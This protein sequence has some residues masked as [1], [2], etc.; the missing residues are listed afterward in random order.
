M[1][2]SYE[3]DIQAFKRLR[4]PNLMTITLALAII[5]DSIY[6]KDAIIPVI[7]SHTVLL[8]PLFAINFSALMMLINSTNGLLASFDARD[9]SLIRY[10]TNNVK[11]AALS[12][13]VLIA[14]V[15][16]KIFYATSNDELNV[17]E[18]TTALSNQELTTIMATALIFILFALVINIIAGASHSHEKNTN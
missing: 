2:D 1:Y 8:A 16:Y 5:S 15:I 12:F 4:I 13:L 9:I 6:S 7:S 14:T 11:M 17:I 10:M 18:N 3:E